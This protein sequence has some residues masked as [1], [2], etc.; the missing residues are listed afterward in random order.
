MDK[1]L[2]YTFSTKMCSTINHNLN[3]LRMYTISQTTAVRR[4]AK[5]HETMQLILMMQ[6]M[7]DNGLS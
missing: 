7:V 1:T 3:R 4:R 2:A 6:F 5:Y